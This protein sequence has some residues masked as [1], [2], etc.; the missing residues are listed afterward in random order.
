MAEV[1]IIGGGIAGMSTAFYLLTE[2]DLS[3]TLLGRDRIG[4]GS[5]A[6]NGGQGVASI[7]RSFADMLRTMDGHTIG[8]LL[9]DIESGYLRLREICLEV[10]YAAGPIETVVWSG[11]SS[12]KEVNIALEE[13]ALRRRYGAPERQI[14]LAKE[15]LNKVKI[16]SELQALTISQSQSSLQE[17]LQTKESYLAAYPTPV[18]LI[19]SGKLC[20]AIDRYLARRYGGRYKLREGSLVTSIDFDTDPRVHVGEASVICKDVVLC[21]NGYALPEMIA[22][23][24]PM[25]PR[26]TTGT[27][28]VGMSV[29]RKFCRNRYITR[30]TST[31]ASRSVFT[32]SSME[33]RTNGI[34]ST[35]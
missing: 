1:V 32:T 19:N 27:A 7:E 17:L 11:L 9:N 35:G 18:S 3:V 8:S 24:T 34:V 28:M 6:R 15:I 25:V 4:L 13:M 12:L 10:E 26:S 29:A 22:E 16:P 31:I 21:T 33:R 2:T 14:T 30:N 20:Q 5:S 23:R